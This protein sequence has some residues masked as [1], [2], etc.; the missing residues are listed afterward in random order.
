MTT[1][2]AAAVQ[3]AARQ[4][5]SRPARTGRPAGRLARPIG[6]Q[7]S[8]RGRR[9]DENSSK[10]GQ[11]LRHGGICLQEGAATEAAATHHM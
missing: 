11:G 2:A 9:G 4:A 1:L 10:Q 8:L 3:A 5:R 6:A 7:T